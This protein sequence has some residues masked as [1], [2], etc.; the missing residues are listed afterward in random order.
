MN[1]RK[2]RKLSRTKKHFRRRRGGMVRGALKQAYKSTRNLFRRRN[3]RVVPTPANPTTY[4]HVQPFNNVENLVKK[5]NKSTVT[6]QSF[7]NVEIRGKNPNKSTATLQTVNRSSTIQTEYLDNVVKFVKAF[8]QLSPE[9]SSE[10]FISLFEYSPTIT[11]SDDFSK[12]MT[13]LFRGGKVNSRLQKD[14]ISNLFSINY[15]RLGLTNSTILD[16]LSIFFKGMTDA[17]VHAAVP[18]KKM[19]VED[20]EAQPNNPTIVN[21]TVVEDLE[22]NPIVHGTVVGH[23]RA[24]D[25]NPTI[26]DVKV[27][28]ESDYRKLKNTH[29]FRFGDYETIMMEKTPSMN[30]LA[31]DVIDIDPDLKTQIFGIT[32]SKSGFINPELVKESSFTKVISDGTNAMFRLSDGIKGSAGMYINV[33]SNVDTSRKAMIFVRRFIFRELFIDAQKD[34]LLFQDG[35]LYFGVNPAKLR[36]MVYPDNRPPLKVKVPDYVSGNN[37]RY[38]LFSKK[39]DLFNRIIKT[40]KYFI[41]SN[42]NTR[43]LNIFH[44]EHTF[45]DILL[46]IWLT[47]YFRDLLFYLKNYLMFFILQDKT[48]YYEA[49]KIQLPFELFASLMKDSLRETVIKDCQY[50][51]DT[52]FNTFCSE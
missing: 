17:I 11:Y 6:V 35:L 9:I 5:P 32:F 39:L 51:V 18:E 16:S 46:C 20:L 29:T 14:E 52:F 15:L 26:V 49:T 30:N 44:E 1:T 19:V 8:K 50:I 12:L 36:G 34:F 23:L 42:L 7:N 37:Y 45:E 47:M 43:F 4:T 33:L 31:D 22:A 41:Y 24:N 28:N 13:L 38:F 48:L 2:N 3:S 25:N 40:M 10:E 27:V 21:A